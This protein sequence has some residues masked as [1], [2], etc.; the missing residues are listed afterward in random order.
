LN[1]N[2]KYISFTMIILLASVLIWFAHQSTLPGLLHGDEIHYLIM[3]SSLINDHDLNLEN[4]YAAAN[5]KLVNNEP[6]SPHWAY[7]QDGVMYSSHEPGL[8]FLMILPYMLGGRTMCVF[9]MCLIAL[10]VALQTYFLALKF[11]IRPLFAGISTLAMS[12]TLPFLM[13][14]GKMF[15]EIPAAF[16]LVSGFSFLVMD[17]KLS[18]QLAGCLM[19]A[20]L[21]WFHLKFSILSL[22]VFLTFILLRR[23][24]IRNLLIIS[25]PAFISAAILF[26]FQ[27]KLFGDSFYLIRIKAGSFQRPF[28]GISGLLFDREVGLLVFAPVT[29]LGIASIRKLHNNSLN[30]MAI[31]FTIFLF[32]S[33][34]WIDWHSGHCPPARYL[35]PM[36]PFLTVFLA[37]ELNKHSNPARWWLF[38]SLWSLSLVQVFALAMT[39]PENAIVHYDGI[40]RLWSEFLPFNLEY[41]A[42]S[43][44]NPGAGTIFSFIGAFCCLLFIDSIFFGNKKTES[45]RYISSFI[46]FLISFASLAIGVNVEVKEKERLATTPL[47]DFGPVIVCP[48]PDLVFVNEVPDLIWKPVPGADG[49]LWIIRFPDGKIVEVPKFG[50]THQTLPDSI[51]EAIPAGKYCWWVIP[52]KQGKRGVSSKKVCFQLIK[53]F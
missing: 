38:G 19:L 40:N 49:Y 16:L 5:R 33:G 26:I 8:S 29:T 47:A 52:V 1:S 4:N 35:I 7:Y 21:P 22:L 37:W 34:S 31:I 24:P 43:W 13:M 51:S 30:A 2:S 48:E 11:H 45:R 44:L 32:I 6:V 42:P 27:T 36:L 12:T 25:L 53:D 39:I 9:A 28:P 15:P 10:L 20:A 14:S 41:L 46:I 23:P 50:S 18:R 3:T 17:K